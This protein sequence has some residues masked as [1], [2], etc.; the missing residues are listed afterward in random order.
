MVEP[1][2]RIV[3]C[4][5]VRTRLFCNDS[6]DQIPRSVNVN[7]AIHRKRVCQQLQRNNLENRRQKIAACRNDRKHSG[8]REQGPGVL[9]AQLMFVSA[10]WTCASNSAGNRVAL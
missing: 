10:Y 6:L 3:T 8:A 2:F 7:A 5:E 1:F 4:N 9:I